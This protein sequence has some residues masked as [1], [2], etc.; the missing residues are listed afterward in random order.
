VLLALSSVFLLLAG[1]S[2]FADIVATCGMTATTDVKVVADLTCA[3]DA[4]VVGADAITINL[5]GHTLKSTGGH[6]IFN[7]GHDFVTIKDGTVQ[8]GDVWLSGEFNSVRSLTVVDTRIVLED[9]DHGLV[10]RNRIKNGGIHFVSNDSSDTLVM[11]NEMVCG[12]IEINGIANT[13]IENTVDAC[14]LFGGIHNEEGHGIAVIGNRVKNGGITFRDVGEAGA[15]VSDNRVSGSPGSGI[16][17]F[18]GCSGDVSVVRNQSDYNGGHGIEV[19]DNCDPATTQLI[20]NVATHNAG[21]GISVEAGASDGGRNLAR[22]NADLRQCVGVL[23]NAPGTT[24]AIATCGMTATSDVSLRSD[25]I[26]PGDGVIV[27]ADGIVIDL[28]GFT[29]AGPGT[30]ID[31]NGHDFVTVKNGKIRGFG[32][33][34]SLRGDFNTVSKLKIAEG[35]GHGIDVVGRRNM[36]LKNEILRW[37]WGIEINDGASD[38]LVFGNRISACNTGVYA[39]GGRSSIMF[40]T[41]FRNGILDEGFSDSFVGNEIEGSGMSLFE[42]QD[43]VV[44]DNWIHESE[45]DGMDAGGGDMSGGMIVRNKVSNNALN[46]INARWAGCCGSVLPLTLMKNTTHYNGGLGIWASDQV[47]DG[48]LNRAK[49]NGDVRQCV[50]VVCRN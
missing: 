33:G 28:K 12:Y 27:G 24:S 36:I 16:S 1:Q 2:V 41:L 3:G 30:G 31:A 49:G 5:T 43:P 42:A 19:S 23:C 13:I 26:C 46:G 32:D 14:N 47:I 39:D 22:S 29:L 9:S 48:G 40:N 10:Y 34:I 20:A 44:L 6:A 35:G 21:L 7:P 8:G 38:N 11:S 17:I 25:L 18:C 50:G 15:V 37:G 4:I 45:G